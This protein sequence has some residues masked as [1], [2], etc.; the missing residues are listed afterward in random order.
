MT[1]KFTLGRLFNRLRRGLFFSSALCISSLS[2]A[3][4]T[5]NGGLSDDWE[6]ANGR[7]PLVADYMVSAG[8]DQNC[9]IDD[10]G[11]VCG[12]YNRFG[13]LNKN[14]SVSVPVFNSATSF[15]FDEN[16]QDLYIGDAVAEGATAYSITGSDIEIT[17]GG[18]LIFL[19][20]PNYE[21]KSSFTETVTATN[22]S[23]SASQV[24]NITINDLEE[25]PVFTSLANF[26][27]TEIAEAADKT[28]SVTV[29][30]NQNGLGNVYVIDGQQKKSITLE[31]GTKYLFN[32]P[33]N[34]PLKFSTTE[35]G[36]LGGGAEY[37]IGIDTSSNGITTI[38]A[39]PDTP[40]TLYYYCSIH[41]GMGAIAQAT[42]TQTDIGSLAANDDD[43]DDL[44]F[45]ISGADASVV[46]LDRIS[47][48]MLLNVVP[49]FNTKNQYSIVASVSDGSTSVEKATYIN[50]NALNHVDDS[51]AKEFYPEKPSPVE[52]DE[53]YRYYEYSW[54]SNPPLCVNIRQPEL[55]EDEWEAKVID[56]LTFA[57]NALGMIIPVNTFV[58]DQRNASTETLR[59]IDRDLCKIRGQ[60]GPDLE[61]CVNN[62]DP[63]GNRFAAAGVAHT[64]LYNGGEL[65]YFRDIWTDTGLPVRI[66]M[67]E[68][69]HTYQ[70][71][72]KFY[73]E[74]DERFGIRIDW[75]DDPD[76]HFYPRDKIIFPGWLEE[77]G[78]DFA[79]WALEAKFDNSRDVR[80]SMIESLDAARNVV[81]VAASQGDSVSLDDYTY[82]GYLYESTDNPNNGI[83]REFAYAYSGGF[84]ALVYLWS[85][86]DANYKKIIVDYYKIYAERDRANPGQG[87]KDAFEELFGMTM[88]KFYEDFDSFM[89]KSREEQIAAIKSNEDWRKASFLDT[90]D[91][92]VDDKADAFPNDPSETIDTD[93]DGI[94][95][96][97]DTDDDNDSVL[98]GD[99]AFPLDATESIDTDSDG[100]GD[101]SD[102][103]PN[104]ASETLD[105]DSDGVG[106]NSD[107]FP[108]NALYKADSDS[109]GM[110]DAWETRYGLDPN[111]PSDATSDIDNDGVAAL[112]EFLAGTI[113]SGSLDIDG[114]AQYDALTDGLLLLRGMFGLDGDA[115][116]AGT[117]AFDA[118]FTASVDIESRIA[119]LGD[120]ADIDGNGE[121]DA[122]TDGLLTLRYLFGLEGDTLIAG[123]VASDATRTTSVDIEAYLKTLMPAL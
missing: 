3:V 106:D 47:G 109:D 107:A 58:V 63:W 11:V 65:N 79:G 43:G 77:G 14:S 75:E 44:T 91:D 39:S 83:A 45:S 46:S 2:I 50:I 119:T 111:D 51:C 95:N 69:Y 35:D 62:S 38:I 110:P 25:A 90:D 78:A 28:I 48:M 92:G 88:D 12:G 13:Q 31:V 49:D 10:K 84:M 27:V 29:A 97:A 56:G 40:T 80:K 16:N 113:P 34:H 15:S 108:N 6:T 42:V 73:F 18:G 99:D 20:S 104:D 89:R 116:V 96:N 22:A 57:K 53:I 87:W 30:E 54:Q 23:G 100:V 33:T 72:M 103:F 71:S 123:V 112:D 114:N 1:N 36:T 41:T 24:I 37:T 86:D 81:N 120:L 9:A 4:D 5:G 101:N 115:L 52:S 21:I 8:Y 102:A 19:S 121:I 85:L 55:L 61:S 117:V 68:Y 66:L 122:L 26:Y 98:D 60:G 59:Q 70:N 7:D 118:A 64:G 93:S 67:H 17:E 32:H 74:D 105:N 94:G 82:K 76:T